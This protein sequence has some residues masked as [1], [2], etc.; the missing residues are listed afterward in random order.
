M[1]CNLYFDDDLMTDTFDDYLYIMRHFF[2]LV[3][4]C[5]VVYYS[6]FPIV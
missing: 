2:I 5:V 3:Y 1:G 6:L 4:N